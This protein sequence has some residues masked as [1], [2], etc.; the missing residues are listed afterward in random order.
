MIRVFTKS[1]LETIDLGQ[2]IAKEFKGGEV[3]ALIGALGTGKTTLTQGILKG[4]GFKAEATSPTFILMDVYPAKHGKIRHLC[5]VDAY[6]LNDERE[7]LDIGI[8]EYLGVNDSVT[9]IEWAD[10]VVKLLP[11]NY[12]KIEGHHGKSANERWYTIERIQPNKA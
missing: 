3:V 6:R 1:A 8:E 7:L 11:A 4:L 9:I 2:R 5:H 10:K 12:L